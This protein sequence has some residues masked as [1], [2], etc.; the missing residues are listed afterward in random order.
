MRRPRSKQA[1]AVLGSRVAQRVPRPD[2]G[3][4]E[5]VVEHRRV[6]QP[7]LREAKD[8]RA[9]VRHAGLARVR[10][11]CELL[12]AGERLE[13]LRR[14]GVVHVVEEERRAFAREVETRERAL[15]RHESAQPARLAEV[16]QE[17]DAA[18]EK[19]ARGVLAGAAQRES[20]CPAGVG[21]VAVERIPHGV[22]HVDL[23]KRRCALEQ[24]DGLSRGDG[25][26][27]R[28]ERT[29]GGQRLL[30][31]RGLCADGG[32]GGLE[33]RLDV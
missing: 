9:R 28:R 17:V 18:G 30:P 3:G 12:H 6:E 21:E 11:A 22:D 26:C 14:D 20:E 13:H 16:S 29:D 7:V 27:E 15:V 25:L 23:A 24:V 8:A 4:A 10:H 19:V 2:D 31:A 1:S 32:A 5:Q 33:Q